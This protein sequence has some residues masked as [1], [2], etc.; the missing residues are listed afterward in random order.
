MVQYTRKDEYGVPIES[1][2]SNQD[3]PTNVRAV[4][5]KSTTR[6][7]VNVQIEGAVPFLPQVKDTPATTGPTSKIMVSL[8]FKN[9]HKK[10][11]LTVFRILI[12]F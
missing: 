5:R 1:N 7:Q 10:Y 3:S 8:F 9:I 11:K 12:L 4:A 6:P 2:Q